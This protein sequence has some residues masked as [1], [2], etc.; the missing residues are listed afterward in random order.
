MLYTR[1]RPRPELLLVRLDGA[2]ESPAS[3]TG[4]REVASLLDDDAL[5]L[6]I[7]CV[8]RLPTAA[9][10]RFLLRL[11]RAS[12]ARGIGF[13]LVPLRRAGGPACRNA[14]GLQDP[15]WPGDADGEP[16]PG[17][18]EDADEPGSAPVRPPAPPRAPVRGAA[19]AAGSADPAAAAGPGAGEDPRDVLARSMDLQRG[20]GM[21]AALYSCSPAEAD[22]VLTRAALAT[23]LDAA[24]AGRLLVLSWGPGG[25]ALTGG[26][27]R[28]LD[29]A[30]DSVVTGRGRA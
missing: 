30:A 18:P 8:P 22:A 10:V 26:L 5:R 16:G 17:A 20:R 14:D 12:R 11:R 21:V 23:G 27:R 3:R 19:P 28:A 7:V 29:E 15:G 25:P 4:P 2:A 9:A 13:R 1:W 6:V 24:E